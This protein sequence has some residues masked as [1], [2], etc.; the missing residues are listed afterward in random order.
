MTDRLRCGDADR[1]T[2]AAQLA[3]VTLRRAC[4]GTGS[5]SRRDRRRSLT[6]FAATYGLASV[7]GLVDRV[8]MSQREQVELV[9]RLADRGDRRQVDLVANDAS[10]PS[11]IRTSESG[12]SARGKNTRSGAGAPSATP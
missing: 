2:Q 3:G 5:L 9:R 8:I 7:E 12:Q 10:Q 6:L 1:D 4:A 11:S